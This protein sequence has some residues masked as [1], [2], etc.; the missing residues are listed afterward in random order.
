[1]SGIF[2]SSS[3]VADRQNQL[4]ERGDQVPHFEVVT[5]DGR[6]VRY[7]D[8]WQ[9]RN[10]ALVLVKDVIAPQSQ[11]YVGTLRDRE[12]DFT[13][14]DSALVVST[15]AI[16]GLPSPGVVIADRWGEIVQVF[17]CNDRSCATPT[18]DELLEWVNFVRIQCPECPP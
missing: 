7:A 5:V 1:M 18:P 15:D 16:G 3:V 11:Q 17:G 13:A 9:H 4:A 2:N 8:L 12:P 6:R 14:A 10:L